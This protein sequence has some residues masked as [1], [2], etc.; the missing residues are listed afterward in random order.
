MICTAKLDKFVN[1]YF[2][3]FFTCTHTGP[4]PS[5]AYKENFLACLFVGLVSLMEQMALHRSTDMKVMVQISL[6]PATVP[7]PP[8]DK[9]PKIRFIQLR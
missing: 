8:K 3:L 2:C 5:I 7:N 6:K 4:S 9:Q 1:G